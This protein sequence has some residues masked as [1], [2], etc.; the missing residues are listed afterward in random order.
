MVPKYYKNKEHIS[1]EFTC[2]EHESLTVKHAYIEMIEYILY[3]EYKVNSSQLSCKALRKNKECTLKMLRNNL[4]K[5]IE[6]TV[7]KKYFMHLPTAEAH[8]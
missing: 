2:E 4:E 3:P 8:K 7:E 6:V 5:V 1:S